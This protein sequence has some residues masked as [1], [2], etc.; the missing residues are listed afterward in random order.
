MSLVANDIRHFSLVRR[1]VLWV[2]M[3]WFSTRNFRFSL[4]SA[5]VGTLVFWSV[6]AVLQ[7]LHQLDATDI[8]DAAG[9]A[10]FYGLCLAVFWLGGGRPNSVRASDS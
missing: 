4:L 9:F 1:E 3:H 5:A 8:P 7:S 6:L 10:G 2:S